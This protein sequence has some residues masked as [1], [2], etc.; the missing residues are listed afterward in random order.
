[1]PVVELVCLANS[2]KYGGRCVA[3]LRTDGG[4]WVRPVARG[5]QGTL[6]PQHYTLNDGTA[7]RLLDVLRVELVEP[8]PEPHHP[9]N[10]LMGRRR[11]ELVARPGG[12]HLAP[13]LRAHLARG[14]ELLGS[15]FDRAPFESFSTTPA[16]ASLALVAPDDLAW[17]IRA[18]L[19]G[20]WQAR[21][22]FTLAGQRYSLAITDPAW[23]QRLC[24]LPAG[25]HPLEAAGLEAGQRVLLTISLGEP[26]EDRCCYKL[27][28]SVLVPPPTWRE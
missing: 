9:E 21:A 5:E 17:S 14:P 27:V 19:S 18:S 16:E 3:G 12:A 26:Y 28:A 24:Q 22:T 10:W 25:L 4:G 7:A 20:R 1:M 11:W 23:E 8:R 6:F 13:L 2:R 15:K